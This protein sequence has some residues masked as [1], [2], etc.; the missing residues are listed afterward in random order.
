VKLKL[1]EQDIQNITRSC[2]R[3]P[4][5]ILGFNYLK[6]EKTMAVRTLLPHADRVCV[7][8]K[9][10]NTKHWM[11]KIH[12]EG[13][14]QAVFPRVPFAFKYQLII[15]SKASGTRIIHDP[16]A[17]S[18][19]IFSDFD[20][21]LFAQGSHYRIWEKLGAHP[22]MRDGICGVHFALWSPQAEHVSVVG[23]FNE[24]DGRCHQ[25][26]CHGHAGIWEI[27]V[28]DI[29]EGE[30]YKYEI[31]SGGGEVTQMSDPFSLDLRS[32]AAA[33]S[34]VY[35]IK[36]K[37][38]WKDTGWKEQKSVHC[39]QDHP[40]SIYSLD[41][42]VNE[43]SNKELTYTRMAADLIPLLK[44]KQF[45]HL[46]LSGHGFAANGGSGY[47]PDPRYGGPEDLM[48][49]VD[50]C[51]Q[52]HISVILHWNSPHLSLRA[53]PSADADRK[54]LHENYRT[55]P[56][57]GLLNEDKNII[58]A[59]A[60][61]WKELYHIDIVQADAATYNLLVHHR[62]KEHHI[63]SG[64]A[65]IVNNYIP[66]HPVPREDLENIKEA[67]H[68]DPHR[69]L[70]PHVLED[71]GS[72][73]IRA[74][75]P[76]ADQVY[77]VMEGHSD[78]TYK[79]TR[80][81]RDGFF[82]TQVTREPPDMRYRFQVMSKDG[83]PQVLHDPYS[84]TASFFSD[85]DRYLF[86]Q[87]THYRIWEKLGAHPAARDGVRGVNFAVWAPNAR[88]VS[89]VGNFNGWDGRCH[90]MR[91]L[92]ESGIWEMFIPDLDEGTC[93]QYEIRA[94][95]GDAIR[96][97]DPYAFYT[98][99]PPGTC[100][101]VYEPA[102]KHKWHDHKWMQ[103]RS[104]ADTGRLPVSIYE[105]HPGSWMKTP[106]SRSFSYRELAA[107]LIP[108]VKNMGFTHIE[109]LP[110]SE[111]PYEPSWGYQVSNFY[112]A[113]SR[114]GKP[115][116]LMV[117]VDTCHQNNIGVILDWVPAHFPKD[118]Y[119]LARFDGTCLYE[120]DDPRLGEHPE[121]GTLIFNYGRHEVENFLIANALFWLETFHFDGLRVDA[122]A[123]ML[124]LDYARKKGEWIPNKHGGNENLEAVEFL[125]HVN[126]TVHEKFP[127]VMMIAEESTA[128][129]AVSKPVEDGGLGFGFKWNMGWMNDVLVYMKKEPPERRHHHNRLTF[130]LMY[131]FHEH[132]ILPLSHDEVVHEKG[133]L[134]NK[135]PGDENQ[136]FANLRLL[137]MYMFTHPGKK[138][139]FMG[140][141]FGQRNEWTHASGLDWKLLRREP[142]LCLQLYLRDLNRLLHAESALF[143]R[144]CSDKGFEWID[145]DNADESVVAFMRRGK[146]SRNCLVIAINFSAVPRMS[147]RIGVPYPATYRELMHSDAPEYGGS[148]MVLPS[149][150]IRA[151]DIPCHGH[152]FSLSLSLPP[153][154]GVVLR[155]LPPDTGGAIE[156]RS[157]I[158]R[159]KGLSHDSEEEKKK[160]IE[161]R[162]QKSKHHAK[163]KNKKKRRRR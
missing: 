127:G 62:R 156:S 99:V 2:H 61:F 8:R 107:K 31:R 33:A 106:D 49:F 101:I 129:P 35:R 45:T 80:I 44:E 151:E 149:S 10:T 30:Q 119:A 43:N 68:P 162:A 19:T 36:G 46:E 139:I 124:Y 72:M 89:V 79:M 37:Y 78:V 144:D 85:F 84:F 142:H 55:D 9:D 59:N 132:F 16:Y 41:T 29:G 103:E 94:R 104:R 67:S 102:E 26:T 58:F 160:F 82:E 38:H 137:Y 1:S 138:L 87:G 154:A 77:A 56:L 140:G 159:E 4:G 113:T 76:Q 13:L 117:F 6:K 92:G 47:A 125:K 60:L 111:H 7:L 108:Y 17:V 118:A 40:C 63:L 18:S 150:G 88:S 14:F 54:P 11:Q 126:R 121:W 141:E 122:V 152:E 93:Y 21:H 97:A 28:P 145:P 163:G 73:V 51:H 74:F 120:H 52:H 32:I 161:T 83:R 157:V 57:N 146:D 69:V 34:V 130:G 27:F 115:E 65:V 50:T 12:D 25:M 136:K 15:E 131:A 153:L 110:I 134:I 148:G 53:E 123:S 39:S 66:E 90:Q 109:L 114:F 75:L 95:N 105:V 133:S 112:A 147:H 98:E 20:R 23:P 64:L 3:A 100:S 116:D 24:W 5:S 81:H 91:L 155:P 143:E 48:A 128:W 22:T 42:Y 96:K 71:T 70:G 86:A 158:I 135:M